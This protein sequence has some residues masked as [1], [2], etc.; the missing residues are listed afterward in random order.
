ME[1]GAKVALKEEHAGT[2]T[3]VCIDQCGLYGDLAL[4]IKRDVV[5][6][7]LLQ[8]NDQIGVDAEFVEQDLSRHASAVD[9]T[10]VPRWCESLRVI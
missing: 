3:M 6:S 2:G 7:V 5:C 4:W 1:N 8:R 9:G 10:V